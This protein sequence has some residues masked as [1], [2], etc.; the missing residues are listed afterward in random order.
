MEQEEERPDALLLLV[1]TATL[2]VTLVR[3]SSEE[4]EADNETLVTLTLIQLTE[5]FGSETGITV[6]RVHIQAGDI[7]GRK[8]VE[9]DI[10]SSVQAWL[11][12]PENNHGFQVSM[13]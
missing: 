4:E 12:R 9:F 3:S 1:S 10:A 8:V 6:E 13:T 7:D 5:E 11:L 2:H